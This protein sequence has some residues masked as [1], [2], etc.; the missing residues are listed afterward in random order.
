MWVRVRTKKT[1]EV[2][3]IDIYLISDACVS[4]PC[5][6]KKLCIYQPLLEI[7]CHQGQ[8]N[9][10]VIQVSSYISKDVKAFIDKRKS[11]KNEILRF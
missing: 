5:I 9:Y 3:I 11:E 6:T 7:N 8:V 1:W 2:P 10:Q 4:R